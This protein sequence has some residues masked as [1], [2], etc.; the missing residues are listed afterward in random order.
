MS[1]IA[2]QA[3][4]LS[5]LYRIGVQKKPARTALGRISRIIASP[6]D[7]LTSQ[8]RGI[9]EEETLWAIKDVSFEVKWGEVVGIIG[10]NGAGKSTLLKILSRITE[11][12]SGEA[13]IY[14]R[15][16]ALLEVGTG[17]HPELT[18]RENIY[19]NGC[20]LGMK[21]AEIDKKFDE[22]VAFSGIERFIDTQVKRYSSG[23]RVRLGFAIA[24]HLEPEILV[25]DEVLAVGDAAFQKRCLGKM[26]DVAGE[27]RTV[28]FVSH[29]MGAVKSLCNRG[30]LINRGRLENEGSVEDIINEYLNF[31][32]EDILHQEW[33]GPEQAPGN[34]RVRV[35][36]L[37]LDYHGKKAGRPIYTTTP[38]TIRY[39]FWNLLENQQ[40]NISSHLK[41]P[42]GEVIFNVWSK[43]TVLCRGLIE[44]KLQIPGEFL[45][46][47]LYLLDLM[48]VHN[49]KAIFVMDSA[50]RFQVHDDRKNAEWF[51]KVKGAIRPAFLE[52]PLE[53]I[54][55]L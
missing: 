21:K 41:N 26:K 52:F 1:N 30:I 15:L 3:R 36:C 33:C 49:G 44:G 31:D 6:F 40:L 4:N 2:I 45:N 17:M 9:T 23:M 8:I 54:D 5:K 16:A 20:I 32:N 7:W 38:I 51:G 13:D 19:L 25:V 39:R 24:A 18:G 37:D 46:D 27:G 43:K 55:C 42:S 14:G 48:L 29:N 53:R 50:F 35:A 11:P 34:E 47:G 22:I 12:T 28:L 10:S